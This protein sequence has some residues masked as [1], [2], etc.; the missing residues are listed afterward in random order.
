MGIAKMGVCCECQTQQFV[1]FY[2]SGVEDCN[3]TDETEG[4]KMD[5]HDFCG[6]PCAGDGTEPQALI[7]QG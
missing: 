1:T 6:S 5:P 2:A 7:R 3:F 4:Y